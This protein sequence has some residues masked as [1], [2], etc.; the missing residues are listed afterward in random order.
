[1]ELIVNGIK[2][3]C[4]QKKNGGKKIIFLHGWGGSTDSFKGVADRLEDYDM[5]LIDM[6]PFGKSGEPT[7]PLTVYDYAEILKE[8]ADICGFCTFSVVAHSFGCRIALKFAAL[9][10]GRVESMVL[11]GA[12]G[13]KPRRSLKYRFKV[14]AYK[15]RKK[16]VSLGLAK[17]ESLESFG[18]EDYKALSGIM[19]KTFVN[20]VNE[21]LTG[22]L[23]DIKCPVLLYFGKSDQDT[24][25]YMA[26]KMEKRIPDC[27]L[28]T[29]E[30]GHFAYL[31]HINSFA[32]IIANFI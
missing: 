17:K 16:L 18:S 1:M 9:Y 15:L 6:P 11:T 31:T 5:L 7:I 32:G 21:D 2:I 3:N 28:I 4:L 13:V 14:A 12:A 30:G 24:P 10:P 20:V 22:I 19:K 27:A 29:A 23:K 26:H 25:L 8:T